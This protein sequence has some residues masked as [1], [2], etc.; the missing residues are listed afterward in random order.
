MERRAHKKAVTHERWREY[1][2]VMKKEKEK[3][4]A[5]QERGRRRARE[6][7]TYLRDMVPPEKDAE[8]KGASPKRSPMVERAVPLDVSPQASR[9]R[10]RA[11][12]V[13]NTSKSIPEHA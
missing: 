12:E 7:L 3:P 13:P 6:A 4:E 10:M 1:E 11:L 8:E 5:V 9:E 2:D